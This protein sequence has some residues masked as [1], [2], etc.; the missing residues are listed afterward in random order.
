M[1]EMFAPAMIGLDRTDDRRFVRFEPLSLLLVY[2]S[3]RVG[4]EFFGHRLSHG[5]E[6]LL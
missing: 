1:H 3:Y 2:H 6:A 4:K 5:L